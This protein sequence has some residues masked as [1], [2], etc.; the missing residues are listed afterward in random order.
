MTHM[1]LRYVEDE[2]AHEIMPVIALIGHSKKKIGST[3]EYRHPDYGTE[4][5][6]ILVHI[7]SM[8]NCKE[9]EAKLIEREFTSPYMYHSFIIREKKSIFPSS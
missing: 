3:V 2:D 7:G 9:Y 8:R 1:L 5:Q 4:F 6:R